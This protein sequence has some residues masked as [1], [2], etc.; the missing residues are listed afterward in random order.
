VNDA[1]VAWAGALVLKPGIVAIGGT[2]SVVFGMTGAGQQIRDYDFRHYGGLQARY[3]VLHALH[4]IVA[5]MAQSADE[6]F[7]QEVLDY[8]A[9]ANVVALA[10]LVAQCDAL[11]YAAFV[12][13]YSGMAPLLTRAALAGSPLAQRACDVSA[14]STALGI[15]LVS[16]QFDAAPI[17]VALVGSVIRS[18]HIAQRLHDLLSQW[19]HES[20]T[21][22][23]PLLPPQAGAV[24]MALDR[25][26]V[27]ITDELIN[28]LR[29]TQLFTSP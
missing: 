17:A 1:V 13:Q 11:D 12:Q 5:G 20:Y 21:I 27:P 15:Q 16:S 23:E 14:E 28:N 7:V 4:L 6:P 24:L 29:K 2:G 3:L 19:A 10:A 22:V 8:F 9:A 18:R 25:L 26:G